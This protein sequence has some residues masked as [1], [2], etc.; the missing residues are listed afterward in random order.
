M[1]KY[2]VDNIAGGAQ[3]N[4]NLAQVGRFGFPIPP[5]HEQTLIATALSDADT[6]ITNLQQLIDKKQNIKKGAMQQLLS[7]KEDWQVKTLGQI[8]DVRDGTHDS[9]VYLS[10][11][12]VFITSKNIVNAKIDYTDVSYISKEDATQINQ[13]SKVDKGDIIMSMIGT[14]GNA[15]LINFEPHFCIKNVALLKPKHINANFLIQLIHSS[16]FQNYLER[17]LDGGI[18]KFISLGVL[19][20]LEISFPPLEIQTQI[21]TILSDMDHEIAALETQLSKYKNI[22]QA[23]M[24]NLLTGKIRL[25]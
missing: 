18:Q 12:I 17:K 13:R 21:A 16:F 7:P 23:M 3:P 10:N 14:I 19:R 2:I 11:G 22:K 5:I 1:Q 8:C 9:P 25:V 20:G 6:L 24:Q 15:V 4:L